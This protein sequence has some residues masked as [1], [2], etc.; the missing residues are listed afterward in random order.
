MK[1]GNIIASVICIIISIY[2]I[3]TAMGYPKAAAYGTGV[4]GPGMW[5]VCIAACMLVTS[6]SLLISTLCKSKSEFSKIEM[7]NDGT[8]RVYLTMVLLTIYVAVLGFLGFIISTIIMLFGFIQW[9]AK[10]K[11][12]IT[13]LIAVGVTLVTYGIFK[14]ILNVPVDFGLFYI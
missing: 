10:K 6:I 8:K 3:I 9:F 14:F 5:P 13:M 1:K 2:V 4:P 12:W 7:W 11:P